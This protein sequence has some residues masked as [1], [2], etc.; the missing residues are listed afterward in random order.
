MSKFKIGDKVVRVNGA[1]VIKTDSSSRPY[2]VEVGG[3]EF[4]CTPE[5]VEKI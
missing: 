3:R 5:E 4:W 2:L 1:E